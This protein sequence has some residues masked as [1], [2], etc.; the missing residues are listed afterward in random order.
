MHMH[1]F[2]NS[3]RISNLLGFKPEQLIGR[4]LYDYHHALD[5][6]A[7]EKSF[8]TCQFSL[9]FISCR[10][11]QLA[12]NT[13]F[14]SIASHVMVNSAMRTVIVIV[15]S[16]FIERHSKAKCTAPTYSQALRQIKWLV[17]R[18]VHSKLRYDFQRVRGDRV[19]VK[20]GVV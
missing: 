20:V 18:V 2:L 7:L 4:S 3:S 11:I 8:R 17:Q 1:S 14:I 13:T 15:I 12:M 5:S 19:A 16:K 6:E 10:F 9:L